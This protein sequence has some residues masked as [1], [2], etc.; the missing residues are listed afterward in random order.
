[1]CVRMPQWLA[2]QP[3]ILPVQ[4][5]SLRKPVFLSLFLPSLGSCA[6]LGRVGLGSLV[7]SA[8]G[9]VLRALAARPRLSVGCCRRS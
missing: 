4:K 5:A 2:E 1:M 8:P 3:S 6:G 7:P 9:S